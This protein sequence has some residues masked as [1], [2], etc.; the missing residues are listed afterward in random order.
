V[1]NKV[2]KKLGRPLFQDQ[3]TP[4]KKGKRPPIPET[5][6]RE[7]YWRTTFPSEEEQRK[8]GLLKIATSPLFKKH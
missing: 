2:P 8:L 4:E 7:Q 3:G 6:D 1:Q 5:P